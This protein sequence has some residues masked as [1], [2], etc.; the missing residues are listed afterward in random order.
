MAYENINPKL[1]LEKQFTTREIIEL[2]G[3]DIEVVDLKPDQLKTEVPVFLGVGWG[4]EPDAYKNN[5]LYLANKGRRAIALDAVHGIDNDIE[6]EHDTDFPDIEMRKVAALVEVLT[7][8]DIAKV[9]AIGYSEGG[10]YITL[11]AILYP[12]KFRNLVLVNPAG[13]IGK[14]NEFRLTTGFLQDLVRHFSD[15]FGNK[16]F[17]K[18]F[19]A[20]YGGMAKS[21]AIDLIKAIK[22]ISA[23]SDFQIQELLQNLKTQDIGISIIHGVDDSTFPMDK[24]QKIVKPAYVDGFYSVQGAHGDF[25]IQ[26][27]KYT[28]IVDQALDALEKK[29]N[30]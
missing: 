29:K 18:R 2:P 10:M 27:E 1:T 17:F 25:V 26:A 11:A 7:K 16:E 30:K 22:E 13:M 3:Q 19:G 21:A 23:M 28:E 15:S 24:M 8:K 6:I 12:E 5:L 14:D 20:F 9:D 4:G